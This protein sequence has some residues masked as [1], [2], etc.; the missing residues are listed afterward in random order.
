VEAHP[1]CIVGL[2]ALLTTTM[3][4]MEKTVKAIKASHPAATVLV[5]GAPVTQTFADQVGADGYAT[6]PQGAVKLLE[7]KAA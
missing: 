6:D 7:R 3:I 2:S 1:G 5:G 4:N